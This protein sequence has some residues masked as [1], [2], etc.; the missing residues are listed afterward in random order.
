[1]EH[2]F[3]AMQQKLLPQRE[4][5]QAGVSFSE[6]HGSINYRPALPIIDLPYKF[7]IPIIDQFQ[8][9]NISRYEFAQLI[10]LY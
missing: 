1:M 3:Q 5:Y 10:S 9:Y 4:V 6:R 8:K 2:Y 7:Q